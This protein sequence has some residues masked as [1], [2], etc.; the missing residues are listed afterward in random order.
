MIKPSCLLPAATV[1]LVTLAVRLTTA[2]CLGEWNPFIPPL[3]SIILCMYAP[4]SRPVCVIWRPPLVCTA[5]M[6]PCTL[7]R[8]KLYHRV[9][10]FI[11]FVSPIPLPFFVLVHQLGFLYV[12]L[13]SVVSQNTIRFTIHSPQCTSCDCPSTTRPRAFMHSC[14]CAT[15]KLD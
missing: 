4:T 10:V 7:G 1:A 14:I 12:R 5:H 8:K 2:P 11:D 9:L 6:S 15:A 13:V 3:A